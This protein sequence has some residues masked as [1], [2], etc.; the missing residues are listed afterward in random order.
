MHHTYT[1]ALASNAL[2]ET[3]E[4]PSLPINAALV[5]DHKTLRALLVSPQGDNL[6]SREEVQKEIDKNLRPD[7]RDLQSPMFVDY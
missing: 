1:R 6:Y 7:W 4:T 3:R 5:T 2:T